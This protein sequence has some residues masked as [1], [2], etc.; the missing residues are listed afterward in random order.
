MLPYCR[1]LSWSR[2]LLAQS[3]FCL[4]V[5]ALEWAQA[6]LP[7]GPSGAWEGLFAP[8]WTAFGSAGLVGFW[9]LLAAGFTVC[10]RALSGRR[11]CD[12]AHPVAL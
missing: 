11:R 7:V 8:L 5:A 2:F 12:A 4:L 3:L 1:V 6:P 10:A 9:L